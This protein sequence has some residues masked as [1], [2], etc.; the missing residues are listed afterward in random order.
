MNDFAAVNKKVE[1]KRKLVASLELKLQG[2]EAELNEKLN[3]L[4]TGKI[5]FSL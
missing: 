1:P 5:S 4:N 2:A 3:D